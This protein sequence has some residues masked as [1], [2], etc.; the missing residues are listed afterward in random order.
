MCSNIQD[1]DAFLMAQNLKA[2]A[3]SY[4]S[5][6]DPYLSS[7]STGVGVSCIDASI[8]KLAQDLSGK[9]NQLQTLIDQTKKSQQAFFEEANA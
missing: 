5:S 7:A 8:K 1:P 4:S 3:L 6:F 9:S 2:A